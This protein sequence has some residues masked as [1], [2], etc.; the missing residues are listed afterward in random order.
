MN[1]LKSFGNNKLGLSALVLYI[2]SN[3][4][5]IIFLKRSSISNSVCNYASIYYKNNNYLK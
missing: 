1:L 4:S 2:S 3:L 5:S